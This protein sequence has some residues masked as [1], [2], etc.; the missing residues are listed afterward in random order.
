MTRRDC[1]Y[2]L[3]LLALLPRENESKA[4]KAEIMRR[5]IPGTGEEI[6]V[7]GLGTWQ[8]FDVGE[9]SDERQPLKGVLQA[10]ID[11]GGSLID[12]S[13]MYGR[14]EKVV[15]DLSNEL[16]LNEKLFIATKVWTTGKQRG[17]E[18]MRESMRLLR[19]SSLDLMQI[20]NLTDWQTHL[21]TLY[22]W[23]DERIIRYIGITH[24]TS[25][26]HDRVAD[27]IA[28]ENIDFV[29]VN[30]NLRDTHA[31]QSLFPLARERK[32]AVLINRPFQEGELFAR[33]KGK[34]LPAWSADFDCHSW[35]QFFLKFILSH[36]AVTCVIPGTSKPHHMQDN[37]GAGLGRLPDERQRAMMKEVL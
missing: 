4:I 28:K 8:T 11:G 6:P 33:V 19:R 36:P 27:I 12:S 32:V 16:G 15:G 7:V 22:R 10:L 5:K 31:E 1:L 34:P 21:E 14:S 17:I 3:S 13:P 35:G 29:Q 24:Y 25:S 23:K 30:Y 26:A 20:H 2:N 37:L 9:S 18:Q